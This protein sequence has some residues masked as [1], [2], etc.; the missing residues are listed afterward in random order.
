[1]SV[2]SG[3]KISE[4]LET[5]QDGSLIITPVLDK[6]QIGPA[7]IDLRLSTEFKVSVPTRSPVLGVVEEAVDTFFQETFREFGEDFIL[8]PN[9]LVLASTFEYVRLPDNISGLIITRSSLNRLGLNVS[10]IVQPGYAG[11]LTLQLSNSGEC[12]IKLRT[13]MRLVQLVLYE[14][15]DPEGSYRTN[16]LSKYVG[17]TRPVLSGIHKDN[18]L[19]IL[20]RLKDSG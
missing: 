15:S 12:A 11:T 9:Q 2:L 10:S 20:K 18:D 3:K 16:S 6:A 1:M 19:N 5:E 14:V 17:D 13:G 4:L 7:S 8:Y